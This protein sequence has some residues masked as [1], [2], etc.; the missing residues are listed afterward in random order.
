MVRSDA[1][2]Q[3][4][5]RIDRPAGVLFG[6]VATLLVSW[7]L[8][9]AV[10]GSTLPYAAENTNGSWALRQLD[11][12]PLPFGDAL[13]TAFVSLGDEVDYARY[14]DPLTPE[15]ITPVRRPDPAVAKAPG[16]ERASASTYK[17]IGHK[18][19][20]DGSQGTV[21]VVGR[22]LLMTAAHV[23][24]G[25]SRLEVLTEQGE[26][27]ATVVACDPEHDV[28]VLSAD[29]DG[30]PLAFAES[31]EHGDD[32]AA[33]GFPLNGDL[34]ITPVRVR[35]RQDF[36]AADINGKG[37]YESDVYAVRGRIH[38]GNSGGPVVTPD[39]RV[40]GVVVAY[41]R[42]SRDTAY[43]NTASQV[44]ATLAAAVRL[45]R[46]RGETNRPLGNRCHR[47][48]PIPK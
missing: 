47:T 38:H 31:A 1:P 40:L 4:D 42:T 22:G 27:D 34:T 2:W 16:V 7:M 48:A 32:A 13:V 28:A 11:R 12:V 30:R 21:F 44:A 46:V 45:P 17:V 23:V 19:G 20:L 15:D 36:Q 37:R 25:T 18:G 6:V 43:V 29:V 39:G 35:D 24:N 8:G 14:V 9:L 3:P 5:P 41:S 10:A 26:V 33:I